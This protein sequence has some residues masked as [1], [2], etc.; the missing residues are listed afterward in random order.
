[1]E[2]FL[3]GAIIIFSIAST[4]ADCLLTGSFFN[5]EYIIFAIRSAARRCLAALDVVF[6]PLSSQGSWPSYKLRINLGDRMPMSVQQD[7]SREAS[8]AERSGMAFT[9]TC[10]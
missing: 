3:F 6:T 4:A 9:T 5:A 2:G 10:S 1:M 8:N 7:C